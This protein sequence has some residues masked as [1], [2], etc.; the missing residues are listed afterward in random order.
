[1]FNDLIFVT[2][3]NSTKISISSIFDFREVEPIQTNLK[4]AFLSW[5][6]QKK[7]ATD[8][9]NDIVACSVN[10]CL[11]TSSGHDCRIVKVNPIFHKVSYSWVSHV[12]TPTGLSVTRTGNVIVCCPKECKVS[13]YTFIGQLLNS[14]DF[15]FTAEGPGHAIQL[16]GDRYIA[17]YD[18]PDGRVSTVHCLGTIGLLAAKLNSIKLTNPCHIAVDSC[19]QVLIVER[20]CTRIILANPTLDR[21]IVLLDTD[22]GSPAPTRIF[23]SEATGRLL[24]GAEDGSLNVYNAKVPKPMA[25]AKDD[26]SWYY[27]PVHVDS[28]IDTRTLAG[29]SAGFDHTSGIPMLFTMRRCVS[30]FPIE[31]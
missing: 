25:S 11:Y 26:S 16:S 15:G 9:L 5:P 23:L 20:G 17:C 8:G 14:F 2:R 31:A 21:H 28:D 10:A 27:K 4:R 6:K 7:K 29:I 18:R 3:F 1:M 24:V 30:L 19:D 22:E 12:G 13:E